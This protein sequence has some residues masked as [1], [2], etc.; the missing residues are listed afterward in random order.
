MKVISGHMPHSEATDIVIIGI[1]LAVAKTVGAKAE[2]LL[3]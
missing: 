2:C 3:C 1:L